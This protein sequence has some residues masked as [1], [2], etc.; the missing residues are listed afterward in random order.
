ML[1]NE[2]LLPVAG[3]NGRDFNGR[4]FMIEYACN[5]IHK[6]FFGGGG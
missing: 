4:P 1:I 3:D 2:G 5:V 6:P